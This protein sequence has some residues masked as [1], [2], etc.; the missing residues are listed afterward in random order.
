MGKWIHKK[1]FVLNNPVNKRW[2]LFWR[3]TTWEVSINKEFPLTF[4]W[5][6]HSRWTCNYNFK[7]DLGSIPPPLEALPGLSSSQYPCSYL[8]HDCGCRH[9][10]LYHNGI[11]VDLTRAQL[12]NMLANWWIP[13]EAGGILSRIVIFTG[14]RIGSWF[15]IGG[16]NGK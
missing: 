15:G 4:E 2:G 1:G 6:E 9:G 10:G 11:F 14:V 8:F 3:V 7:S 5:S 12:D 16:K 13:A